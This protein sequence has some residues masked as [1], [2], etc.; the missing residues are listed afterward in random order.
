MIEVVFFGTPEFAVPTLRALASD[1]RLHLR[2]VV[3][4]PDRPAGRARRPTSPPVKRAARELGLPVWQPDTLRDQV[5]AERLRA[6]NPTVFVVAAY[7]A[8]FRQA[9]LNLP[10]CGTLNVHPSL[11]PRYRG[12]SPIQAAI[13]NGDSHS[14]VSLIQMVRRLDAGPILAQRSIPLTGD[15]TAGS[16]SETLARLAAEMVPGTTI[17]WCEGR[18]TPCAQREDQATFTVRLRKEDGLIDWREDAATIARRVRAMA[19][20]P[21]AWTTLGGRRLLIERAA[22]F[23]AAEALPAQ[24]GRLE[25]LEGSVR[26]R[27]GSGLLELQEVRPEG[28][29]SQPAAD[30]YRGLRAGDQP[31]FDLP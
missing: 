16:L 23:D 24:P 10:R 31:Q 26:V 9:I 17:D 5:A 18:L 8:I 6:L 19:P 27:C 14:G 4:Q 28:R 15:E 30:W 22:P 3:T 21:G 1:A 2:L 11:L 25:P 12:S 20:W 13:L 7:A 29:S